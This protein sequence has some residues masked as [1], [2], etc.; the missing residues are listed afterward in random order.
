MRFF[1]SIIAGTLFLFFLVTES[2]AQRVELF[3]GYSFVRA[4]V[5]FSE[6]I[7]CSPP[8]CVT[9]SDTRKLNL[10]GWEVGGAFKV[11]G[12]LALAA[13]FSETSA[14]FRGANTHLQTYLVGPQ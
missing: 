4:P 1:R 12:P 3:G 11:L 6:V 7:S 13:D 2:Y 8:N 9:T 14:S 5:T 10:N